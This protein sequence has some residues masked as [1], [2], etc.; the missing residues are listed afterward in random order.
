MKIFEGVAG[1]GNFTK[2]IIDANIN[3]GMGFSTLILSNEVSR[4]DLPN[5]SEDIKGDFKSVDT[6]FCYRVLENSAL[7]GFGIVYDKIYIHKISKHRLQEI[8]KQITDFE[9]M[10][11]VEITVCVQLPMPKRQ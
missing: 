2:L 6:P 1:S 5:L 10:W 3:E 9:E 4:T 7:C 11:D 8:A